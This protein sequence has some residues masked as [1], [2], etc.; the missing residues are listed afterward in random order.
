M[1]HKDFFVL[2]AVVHPF[3]FAEENF[4]EPEGARAMAEMAAA[5]RV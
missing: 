5:L 4:A 2:D 1:A 3:N